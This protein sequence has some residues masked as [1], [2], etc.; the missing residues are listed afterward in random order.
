MS[1]LQTN[2]PAEELTDRAVRKQLIKA[3]GKRVPTGAGKGQRSV[4][5]GRS[6]DGR[7]G[8]DLTTEGAS[9]QVL[10][11]LASPRTGLIAAKTPFTPL[12]MAA[13]ILSKHVWNGW[14]VI[15]IRLTV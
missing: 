10:K 9:K 15:A 7:L 2:L 13:S 5:K 11:K 14:G 8:F 3:I 1:L 4:P 12:P 6:V